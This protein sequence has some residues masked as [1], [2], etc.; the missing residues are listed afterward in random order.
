MN[1]PISGKR[2]FTHPL[3]GSSLANIL[4]LLRLN[5]GVSF[6]HLPQ[7]LT[8]LGV[9]VLRSP[10]SFYES[11]AYQNTLNRTPMSPPVFI[12]GHWRSGTTHMANLLSRSVEFGFVTPVATGLPNE[13][14]TL[15][16][17]FK[18]WLERTIP[19]DRLIDQ[20]KVTSHSPQEDEFGLANMFT[21]SFLHAL[22]F[23]RQF[24]SNF[25][26]GVF[27]QRWSEQEL[28]GWE[29]T[30]LNYLR[31]I[32]RD[33]QKPRLLIRNPAYTCRIPLLRKIWPGAKFIHIHR[34]PYRVFPSMRNYFQKLLPVL[35]LQ[36]YSK[37]NF[38]RLIISTYKQMMVTVIDDLM[39]LPENEFIEVPYERLEKSPLVVLEEIYQRLGL[40]GYVEARPLF[41]QYLD[42][43]R[44]YTKNQ[45][46]QTLIERDLIGREWGKVIEH[47]GY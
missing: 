4:R 10:F 14:L 39:E 22:Y 1:R 20:V 29:K 36:D 7:L 31:K 12:V 41:E 30:H 8:A 47:Y 32:N 15:G 38:D 9:S 33:Q 13:L 37:V 46:E 42:G 27:H 43:I 40:S 6:K 19:A 17:W 26:K 5:G 35:A 25:E 2:P 24:E 16:K 21:V 3:F 44:G 34:N 28:I 45:Y 18:P 23:P 11:L